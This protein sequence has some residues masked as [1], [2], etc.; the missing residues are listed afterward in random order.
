MIVPAA[1]PVVIT[2]VGV[3][4]PL[5]VGVPAFAAALRTAAS[6]VA[7]ITRFDAAPY[8]CRIAGEVRTPEADLAYPIDGKELRTAP[9]ATRL[10]LAAGREA[11]ETA[12]L[13]WRR[14]DAAEQARLG[15]WVGT[16]GGGVAWGETQYEVLY[17][18]GW[19]RTSVFGVINALLGMVSSELSSAFGA[20]GPSHV[21]STGC[22]S[23]S[24]ALG[25]AAQAVALG[26][27]DRALAG[28]TE[29]CLTPGIFSNFCRMKAMSTAFNATPEAASRPFD[30]KRDGFVL[31][32]G[33]WF[34]LLEAA[35]VARERGAPILAEL[36]GYAST[37]DAFHRTRN[38]PS[39]RETARAVAEALRMA[40]AT[41]DDVDYVNLHGTSTPLNDAV[42]TRAMKRVFGARTVAVPMSSLKSQLG[43]PQGAAGAAGLAATLIALRDGFVPATRN[44]TDPDPE[45]DL[46]Y[47][48]EGPRLQRVNLAVVNCISFGSKNSALVVRRFSD[49]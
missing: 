40:G 37:C 28:G 13:D 2:G 35:N 14:L 36:A 1:R 39:G 23:S 9:R 20:H 41:P 44:L 21:L 8:P 6:G 46:D 26:Q 4:S 17:R 10:A 3:V 49:A 30:R 25:Y 47:V 27:V 29:A 11:F 7:G 16:G 15:V 24:D 38:E 48:A 19:E 32:E 31:A 45:C 33:A 43:H 22:T 12:G 18:E 34:F 42:E 5:G